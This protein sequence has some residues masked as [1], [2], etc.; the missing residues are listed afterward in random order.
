MS[1]F[2]L[3]YLRPGKD[4][5]RESFEEF[6][7]QLFRRS[8]GGDGWQYRRISG[9]GGD[10]GVEAIW[11]RE[12]GSI[13][14][15][16]A[17][18]FF[19]FGSSEK[20][21][22][23][24]SLD[25][26]MANYGSLTKYTYT[27]PATLTGK[28]G[29]KSKRP[30]KGQHDSL[31]KWRE[32]WVEEY[33]KLGRVIEID[34]W[35]EGELISR[36]TA[37]DLNGGMRRYWFDRDFFSAQWFADHLSDAEAQAGDRYS[38]DISLD[39]PLSRSSDIFGKTEDADRHFQEVYRGFVKEVGRWKSVLPG[40]SGGLSEQLD[41]DLSGE[42]SAL[43]GYAQ[44]ALALFR[45]YLTLPDQKVSA[46]LS[47]EL[48]DTMAAAIELE[49]KVRKSLEDKHGQNA[50]SRGF[51]QFS[52][53]Y[54]ASF[55][56]A[57]LDHLR[58]L[59]SALKRIIKSE[60]ELFASHAMLVKGPA[61][62]GKTHGVIDISKARLDMGLNSIIS[63]GEDFSQGDPWVRIAHKLGLSNIGRE[64]LL[65]ILDAAGE[66]TGYPLVIFI[67]ALN[68]TS[69]DRKLWKAWLPPIVEQIRR[70]PFVKLCVTCRD[71]Y[72][73]D[74][75][76][77][78]VKI[79]QV[80][81]NGFAGRMYDAIVKFFQYYGL[82]VPSGPLLQDEFS[83]P[84]F[85]HLVCGALKDSGE[86]KLPSGSDGFLD[87]V[88]LLINEK[89]K[90]IATVCD[91]DPRKNLV[92]ESVL[93][94]ASS[95]AT[96]NSRMLPLEDV[97][98]ALDH[99]AP[100]SGFSSS[101]VNML[102]RESLL[103]V[104]EQQKEG[105][106]GESSYFVR[107]TF[108]RIGDHFIAE[109]LLASHTK[110]DIVIAMQPG[111][112]LHFMFEDEAAAQEHFG[113]LEAVSL[114]LVEKFERELPSFNQEGTEAFL[115]K[116][117]V[118]ALQWRTAESFSRLTIAYFRQALQT[119]GVA[120]DA[121]D[122]L[123]RLSI[124]D[125]H[126]LNADFMH[127]WWNSLH[128]LG[129]D[130]FWAFNLEENYS[131]W[132]DDINS[133]GAVATLFDWGLQAPLDGL[134]TDVSLL[135]GTTFSWF[136]ASPDRRIRDKATKGLVRLAVA[137][138]GVLPSLLRRFLCHD[139]EYVI[140]RVLTAAYGAMLL[141]PDSDHAKLSAQVVA[142]WFVPSGHKS[143]PT[144]NAIIRD[145][146][147]SILEVAS[148]LGGVEHLVPESFRP[149]Y[150]SPWPIELPTEDEVSEYANDRE[151]YPQL[152][153]T[154]RQGLGLGTDFARYVV[155]PRVLNEFDCGAMGIEA[156]DVYRWFM[157]KAV[158]DGYPGQ[159]DRCAR[160]D[161]TILSHFGGGRGKP[162]WAERLGKKYYWKYLHQLV[163]NFADHL[164]RID[165]NRN[166]IP[167]SDGLQG[168]DLRDIDPTDLRLFA[169]A[170]PDATSWVVNSPCV[171]P[172]SDSPDEDAEWVARPDDF[173]EL[174]EVLTVQSPDQTDWIV[175]DL[176]VR[177]DGPKRGEDG[178]GDYRHVSRSVETA[179][180]QAADTA[181]IKR[182]FKQE[183]W[184]INLSIRVPEDYRG[185]LGEY[186]HGIAYTKRPNSDLKY[187]EEY[188]GFTLFHS[189]FWQLKGREW[190][191][192]YSSEDEVPSLIMPSPGLIEY[193]G[194]KW[195]GCGS[196]LDDS[197]NTQ[198]YA[199]NWY[200]NS[201]SA[202]VARVDFI[203]KYLVDAEMALL[204]TGFQ[205]KF[206]AGSYDDSVGL[207]E[208]FSV[209]LRSSRRIY[210]LGV[211]TENL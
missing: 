184:P 180:C 192:D 69:P 50:D 8:E 198:V 139:D 3:H 116:P 14:G 146:A 67:D 140:E 109:H 18:Y 73:R 19:K 200:G 129:R 175:L 189:A 153:L 71:T 154:E 53:E 44:S 155:S 207:K 101:M 106:G 162:G 174:K 161:R 199:T 57:P 48:R 171:F 119:P 196:W 32:E 54:N 17:K 12:D 46:Q 148:G 194:L 37:V 27:I 152:D 206:I 98:Q 75:L 40:D 137:N 31:G 76:A 26:A 55:P 159:E 99:V 43:L 42:A 168:V 136:L 60:F 204:F 11:E 191:Y 96:Q 82:G 35:D 209:Y 195:D 1:D 56:M 61:G 150:E 52:A 166:V 112:E 181:L 111:G 45:G 130:P 205:Q 90:K 66:T 64:Q 62:I 120:G 193:G 165:W 5:I 22:M 131:M 135:W 21:Q 107:F 169:D 34:Y 47:A 132:G 173:P 87:V 157:Q 203:D 30:T 78:S 93:A 113:L 108:E 144:T 6:C 149:P 188:D 102:E 23:K 104:V 72:L 91:Y 202:L 118:G 121:F 2:D 141:N 59:I 39:T 79:P 145:H 210:T 89:N 20:S 29:G 13:W 110:E 115:L 133:T 9:A 25:Q 211:K 128:P 70:Y 134:A 158:S 160:F 41:D 16:Q 138:P 49:P 51:R 186:P 164:P 94:I 156:M 83:N 63:F 183:E 58:D 86:R 178:S 15:L 208:E 65:E 187:S 201:V 124:R 92:K 125:N 117:F 176:S 151:R 127:S 147:R 36:L 170:P 103:A 81:H 163:G 7:C 24:E 122:A 10:G 95:M 167:P 38:P 197:G 4:G 185:Y 177:W 172:I 74:V 80:S 97:E 88:K 179:F 114:L 105:L 190:E 28:K 85:L 126:P 142:D 143:V 84:L 100:K 123:L 182:K 33:A 68:E 77:S